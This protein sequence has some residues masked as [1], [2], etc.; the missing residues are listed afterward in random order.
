MRLKSR[1]FAL[2]A[3]A[4][5][6][7]T[8]CAFADKAN[9]TVRIPI[10]ETLATVW[11]A[12][13]PR[14]ETAMATYSIFD[15]LLCYDAEGRQFHPVLA[16]SW[17]QLN[18]T[19]FEFTLRNDVKW[20]DGSDFTIEDVVYSFEYY[21][22]RAASSRFAS[23]FNWFE[24][25][26]QTGPDTI[27]IKT[28]APSPKALMWLAVQGRIVPAEIHRAFEDKSAFGRENPVGTGPYKFVSMDSASGVK[29]ELNEHYTQVAPCR[30]TGSIG[31]VELIPVPDTQTQLAQLMTGG[32][33]IVKASSRDEAE[34]LLAN[35]AFEATST[36]AF[37]LFHLSLDA[38]NQS[39]KVPFLTDLR[40]REAIFRS[41][42]RL[43]VATSVLPGGDALQAIDALCLPKQ[44]GCS[45][46][47]VPDPYDPDEARRLLAEAG[48]DDGFDVIL[49]A[50]TGSSVLA[51]AIAG[52]MR[53]VGIR[54]AVEPVTFPAY[55]R[56]EAEGSVQMLVHYYG[57]EDVSR[58]VDRFFGA[59]A[60][61]YWKD[62][63]IRVWMAEAETTLDLPT[64]EDLYKRIFDRVNENYYV[65]A[66]TNRPDM[67][68]HTKDLSLP[69]D[70]AGSFGLSLY[71]LR[72]K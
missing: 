28:K 9:D 64:R 62:E 33:D 27:E 67:F 1:H 7:T 57:F 55:S 26:T 14:P 35:P 39:G 48:Y 21:V 66:L 11:A 3:V 56:K 18:D 30:P 49:T 20:H 46:T 17:R 36:Q 2:A 69:R 68:I 32:L 44:R 12:D 41:I 38:V 43:S 63:D 23:E 10:R 24:S 54:A 34:L 52:E 13:D 65:M 19:T 53:K 45:F 72:W 42:D 22:D 60:R 31:T 37:L 61:D 5:L 51:E 40:V 25:A 8:T 15:A 59:S 16:Q 29:L 47:E 4:A 6:S 50:P 71:D 70:T 58:T